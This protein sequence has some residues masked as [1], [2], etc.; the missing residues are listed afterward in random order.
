MPKY[1]GVPMGRIQERV[2]A[3]DY[4]RDSAILQGHGVVHTA[5]GAGPSIGNGG[6]HEI[7][8]GGQVV[9]DIVGGG[10]GINIL[11]GG[12]AFP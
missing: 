3:D 9:D 12:D 11:I 10:P 5:R 8:P 2:G 1:L 4:S 7:A 6:D